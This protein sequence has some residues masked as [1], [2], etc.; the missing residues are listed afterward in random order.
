MS[1]LPRGWCL[2][3]E[4]FR[5]ELLLQ[6]ITVQGSKFARP[7]WQETARKKAERILAEELQRRGWGVQRLEHL[8]KADPEKLRI[9][10][11]LRAETTVTLKWITE[12]LSM[13]VPGYVSF[14][15]IV[16]LAKC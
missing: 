4:Q 12:H 11:R 2:G 1:A 13:A 3:S 16:L 15:D 14:F 9:A 6:M 8:R 5:Q 7:E 10:A